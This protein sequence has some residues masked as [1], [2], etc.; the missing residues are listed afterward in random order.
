MDADVKLRTHGYHYLYEHVPNK[1][2]RLEM[3]Y[4]S[5]GRAHDWELEKFRVHLFYSRLAKN[6]QTEEIKEDSLKMF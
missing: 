3:I 4:R 5:M 2:E 1:R 6:S